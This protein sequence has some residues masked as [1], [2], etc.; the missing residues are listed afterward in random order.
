MVHYNIYTINLPIKNLRKKNKMVRF[1]SSHC[2]NENYAGN[3]VS[4]KF[5]GFIVPPFYSCIIIGYILQ[6]H[7]WKRPEKGGG[8]GQEERTSRVD[9]I[10]AYPQ[11][12]IQLAWK[13]I[14]FFSSA[15]STNLIPSKKTVSVILKRHFKQRPIHNGTLDN[16]VWC[17]VEPNQTRLEINDGDH[18]FSKFI[19]TFIWCPHYY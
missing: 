2:K 9:H 4:A 5:L 1:P 3:L 7:R 12:T 10:K 8:G 17:K 11:C 14:I 13:K 6:P 16:I 19:S 15:F 18:C